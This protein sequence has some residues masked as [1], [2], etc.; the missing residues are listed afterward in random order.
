[1]S[2]N[3]YELY[4]AYNSIGFNGI[5]RLYNDICGSK[6]DKKTFEQ[7]IT[8]L[9][10]GN[11]STTKDYKKELIKSGLF[12]NEGDN[13]RTVDDHKKVYELLSDIEAEYLR[14]ML[15][16]D[17]FR[18]LLGEDLFNKLSQR[19]DDIDASYIRQNIS[20]LHSFS[21]KYSDSSL[22]ML[23][24]IARAIAENKT[25]E[26]VYRTNTDELQG[27]ETPAKIQLNKRNGMIQIIAKPVGGNRYIKQSLHKF[28]QVKMTDHTSDKS[29]FAEFIMS[30]RKTVVIT[31]DKEKSKR[32]VQT[33]VLRRFLMVFGEMNSK[34]IRSEYD[35]EQILDNY[36]KMS[37][38]NSEV[39]LKDPLEEDIRSAVRSLFENKEF[40]EDHYII[41]LDYF[42]FPDDKEGFIAELFTFGQY[43]TV[44]YPEDIRS[45]LIRRF[46]EFYDLL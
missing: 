27:E 23:M 2:K 39:T 31:I 15:E 21:I 32:D 14:C 25:I 29:D 10:F 22:E 28:I 45:E 17:L 12:I 30:K 35:L 1:M 36:Y 13:I 20:T 44:H 18:R 42:D 5:I 34:L 33:N 37:T 41:L 43:I 7:R 4:K 38:P 9:I 3:E 11:G 26:Y 46:K 16:N 40:M 19:T 8:E 6:M 24:T